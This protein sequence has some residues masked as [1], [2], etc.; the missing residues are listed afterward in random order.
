V[1]KGAVTPY[2]LACRVRDRI[3]TGT[4]VAT[5]WKQLSLPAPRPIWSA[6]GTEREVELP[7][8]EEVMEKCLKEM[9]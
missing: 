3:K 2:E 9:L 4:V 6:L 1:N 5:E 8:L 7:P